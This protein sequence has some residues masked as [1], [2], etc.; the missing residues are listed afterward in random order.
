MEMEFKKNNGKGL[1]LIILVIVVLGVIGYFVYDKLSADD[2]EED[3]K[4]VSE[5]W[6]SL[7]RPIDVAG[8]ELLDS[9]VFNE[10]TQAVE[11]E[12][13]VIYDFDS[14]DDVISEERVRVALSLYCGVKAYGFRCDD[15]D[16][17]QITN[18]LVSDLK[19]V[20]KESVIGGFGYEDTSVTCIP[21]LTDP[22]HY[23]W[24]YNEDTDS[25]DYTETGHGLS[26]VAPIQKELIDF[27]VEDGIYTASYR[28]I[29]YVNTSEAGENFDI[30]GTYEDAKNHTDSIG[31]L[32]YEAEDG[33]TTF[34]QIQKLY[35]EDETFKDDLET[36]TYLFKV[37]NERLKFVS[38]SRE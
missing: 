32:Y 28:Y 33:S 35:A 27:Y 25:Y 15:E 20:Y 6:E 24:T 10:I 34:Q 31:T 22:D 36:Y 7:G 9:D 4:K 37:E 26:V 12:L 19:D 18:I 14:I 23:A 1:L 2:K 17:N 13:F 30:Y 38:F 16:G 21:S 3:D 11:E 29:W 8:D 5:K